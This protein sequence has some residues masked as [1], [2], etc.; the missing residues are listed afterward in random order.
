MVCNRVSGVCKLIPS[1][2]TAHSPNNTSEDTGTHTQIE[3]D[4]ENHTRCFVV[5]AF[6]HAYLEDCS[7]MACA[8]AAERRGGRLGAA[9][10]AASRVGVEAASGQCC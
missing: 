2:N 4:L 8:F 6:A 5:C 1:N 7:E 3:R 9:A 10:A